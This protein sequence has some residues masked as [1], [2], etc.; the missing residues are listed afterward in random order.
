MR[1]SQL[2]RFTKYYYGGQVKEDEM[3]EVYSTHETDERCTQHFD[4]KT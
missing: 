2:I 3:G 4:R 1:T